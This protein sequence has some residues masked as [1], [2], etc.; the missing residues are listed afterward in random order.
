MAA[1][2]GNAVRKLP[3]TAQEPSME[4]ILTSIKQIIADDEGGEGRT[5]S[6]EDFSHPDNPS[7]SNR[8][9]VDDIELQAAL[10]AELQGIELSENSSAGSETHVP[11][12]SVDLE[13]AHRRKRLEDR[14]AAVRN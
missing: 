7:N 12:G 1:D 13:D 2:L 8:L 6:R 5:A 10:E 11:A 14:V 9:D 4:E 3:E